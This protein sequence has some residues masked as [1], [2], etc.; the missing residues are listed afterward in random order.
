MH[1]T[2]FLHIK[3]CFLTINIFFSFRYLVRPSPFSAQKTFERHNSRRKSNISFCSQ[4]LIQ[5]QGVSSRRG[6]T[7]GAS[8]VPPRAPP[9]STTKANSLSLPDSPTI[10]TDFRG[11]SNS[12][13]VVDDILLRRSNSLRQGLSGVGSRRR[14][15]SLEEIGISHFNSLLQH[16]QQQQ[17]QNAFKI[18]LNGSIGL[19]VTPP[20]EHPLER[21]PG[22]SIPLGGYQEVAAA[23]PSSSLGPSLPSVTPTPDPQHLQGTIV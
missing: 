14:K 22:P 13:R 10:I 3:N 7:I 18:A 15:S 6:S 16:Q 12:L 23:L 19:E 2:N 8:F 21:L 1:E 20:E 11:R 17:Q 4:A 5:A 9:L